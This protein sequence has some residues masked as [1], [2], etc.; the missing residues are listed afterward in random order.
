LNFATSN[1]GVQEQP[2]RPGTTLTDVVPVQLEWQDGYILPPER[3]G[4][5]IELDR[6]AARRS[7]FQMTENPHL[8]RLDG[9]FTNW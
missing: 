7:P 9:S 2:R 1:V 4:L 5:G 3:P 6:D 8:H